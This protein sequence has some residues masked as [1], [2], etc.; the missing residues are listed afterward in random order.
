MKATVIKVDPEKPDP[1]QIRRAA[2]LVSSGKI[3]AFPTETV[4][5]IGAC[6]GQKEAVERLYALKKRPL[7]KPLAYHIGDLGTLEQLG[8]KMSPTFR[9]LR[10]QFWPGPVTFVVWNDREEKVGLRFPNHE[11]AM[12]LFSQ[13]GEPVVAT[14]ANMSG[15]ESPKTADDVLA[16]MGEQIDLVLDGGR[17]KHG[18]D[19]TVLDLT[20][21]PPQIVRR[22]AEA[23][24]I[25]KAIQK[26]TSGQFPRKKILIVCT[27]N[28]CRSPMAEGWLKAELKRLGLDQQIEVGSGGTHARL[29]GSPTM[30]T[31]LALKNDEISID[32]FHSRPL[33]REEVLEADLIF[34]MTEEHRRFITSFCPTAGAKIVNLQID[35]PVG[36]DYQVY[37]RSY[38]LIK[39]RI[40]LHWNEVT[41]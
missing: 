40:K 5:G 28:T 15:G 25:E 16:G 8:V 36:M 32:H 3:V 29:G 22:G 41:S 37:L 27:G 26:I 7:D 12:K 38:Q 31:L 34:V 33:S 17:C 9:F 2:L 35:D 6:A 1:D 10:R 20:V 11:V 19:S 18:E 14:S 13:I 30:E 39:E 21:S 23:E 4:Y 24:K